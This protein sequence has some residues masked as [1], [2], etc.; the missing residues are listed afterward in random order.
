MTHGNLTALDANNHEHFTSTLS[1]RRVKIHSIWFS[2]SENVLAPPLVTNYYK[3]IVFDCRVYKRHRPYDKSTCF[4][5]P[6]DVEKPFPFSKAIM[7]DVTISRFSVKPKPN[8]SELRHNFTYILVIAGASVTLDGEVIKDDRAIIP[9]GCHKAKQI[10]HFQP[11]NSSERHR[12]V[13]VL[14][15]HRGTTFFHFVVETL[16]RIAAYLSFLMRHPSIKVL[17]KKETGFTVKFL[18]ALGIEHLGWYTGTFKRT[19]CTCR[20]V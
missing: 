16:T 17:V 10:H 15:Q 19:S 5:R 13:F 11:I 3:A 1:N 18:A 12:E 9:M 7:Q 2:E 4:S 8:S 6:G 14:A 20:P